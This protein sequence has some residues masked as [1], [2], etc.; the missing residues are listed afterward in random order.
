[1]SLLAA[2]EAANGPTRSPGL[3]R[4]SCPQSAARESQSLPCGEGLSPS[5][6][7]LLL[8]AQVA[9]VSQSSPPP[10]VQ[11][12]LS[13]SFPAQTIT[14]ACCAHGRSFAESLSGWYCS[15]RLR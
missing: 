1:M 11:C 4:D 12:G 15:M 8:L 3:S 2:P 10:R 14:A 9:S 6:G 7:L 13:S 5:P